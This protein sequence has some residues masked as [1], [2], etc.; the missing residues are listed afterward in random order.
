M[1][2]TRTSNETAESACE[3]HF[4]HVPDGANYRL[5]VEGVSSPYAVF[6]KT[7]FHQISELSAPTSRQLFPAIAEHLANPPNPFF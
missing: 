5:R 1:S 2:A 4:T 3:L 6:N 7:K